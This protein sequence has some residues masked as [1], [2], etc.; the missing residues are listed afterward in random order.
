MSFIDID[1]FSNSDWEL[2]LPQLQKVTGLYFQFPLFDMF[3]IGHILVQNIVLICSHLLFKVMALRCYCKFTLP[4]F[5][6]S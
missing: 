5:F 6:F 1:Y 2:Y 4:T 3:N